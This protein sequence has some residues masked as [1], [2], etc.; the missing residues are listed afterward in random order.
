MKLS[1]WAK[2][3]GLSYRTAWW[4]WR[5]GKLPVPAEQLLTGTVLVHPP[6]VA[7][8]GGAALYARVSSA[9]QKTWNARWPGWRYTLPKTACASRRW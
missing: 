5:D 2:S 3:Q 6:V 4:L 9:D 7:V 8:E 1:V